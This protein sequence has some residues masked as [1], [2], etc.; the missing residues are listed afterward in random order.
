MNPDP[1][2]TQ[3]QTKFP[4]VKL[5]DGALVLDDERLDLLPF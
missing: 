5:K 3:V 1:N 2:D 4:K